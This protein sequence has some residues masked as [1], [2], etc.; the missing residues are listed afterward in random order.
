MLVLTLGAF[1][2]C[3]NPFLFSAAPVQ[4]TV[5]PVDGSAVQPMVKAT[6]CGY[7]II[8][9]MFMAVAVSGFWAFGTAVQVWG[10]DIHSRCKSR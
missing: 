5:S 3:H 6:L 4:S 8:F 7:T 2:C 10:G 1:A 9:A